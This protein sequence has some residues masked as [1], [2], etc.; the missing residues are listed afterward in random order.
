MQSTDTIIRR[1]YIAKKNATD[2]QAQITH[3]QL[4]DYLDN[5]GKLLNNQDNIAAQYSKL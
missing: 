2:T 4:H 3:I 1:H 5:L